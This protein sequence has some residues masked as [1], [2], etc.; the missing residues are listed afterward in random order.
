MRNEQ[1]WIRR[2]EDGRIFGWSPQQANK[3][4]FV[5]CDAKGN[6]LAAPPATAA[7]APVDPFMQADVDRLNVELTVAKQTIEAQNIEI[8]DLRAEVAMLKSTVNAIDELADDAQAEISFDLEA[9]IGALPADNAEAKLQL[10]Q[11]AIDRYGIDLDRRHSLPKMIEQVREFETAR[12]A[13]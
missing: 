1:R 13:A 9:V 4:G 3:E 8:N 12:A 11:V 7:P 10:G 6:L 5:E 2:L